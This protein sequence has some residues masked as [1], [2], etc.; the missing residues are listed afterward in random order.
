VTIDELISDLI[1]NI[2]WAE[3]E[4]DKHEV[5]T[6]AHIRWQNLID[7]LNVALDAAIAVRDGAGT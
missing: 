4:R 1:E 6:P 7:A 2:D 5:G 3:G